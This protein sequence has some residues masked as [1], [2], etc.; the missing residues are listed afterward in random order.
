MRVLKGK[1]RRKSQGHK[2]DKPLCKPFCKSILLFESHTVSLSR[3]SSCSDGDKANVE[4]LSRPRQ[5]NMA[6][7]GSYPSGIASLYFVLGVVV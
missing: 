7:G 3:H 6:K 5:S 1:C 4:L 2:V